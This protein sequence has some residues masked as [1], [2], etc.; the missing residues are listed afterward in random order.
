MYLILRKFCR[1]FKWYVYM[2]PF[3]CLAKLEKTLRKINVFAENR[4]FFV[5]MFFRN[6]LLKIRSPRIVSILLLCIILVHGSPLFAG[7]VQSDT[8][9]VPFKDRVAL[10]ANAVDWLLQ[11]PA[12]GMEIG[13]HV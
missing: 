5:C 8:V 3:L 11:I 13:A 10:H 7:A 4:N 2:I 1:H 9:K 6:I 12:I